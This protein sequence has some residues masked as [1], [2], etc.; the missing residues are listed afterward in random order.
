MI[1]TW[2]QIDV[3]LLADVFENFRVFS[4]ENYKLDPAHFST[5]PGLS[6]SAALVYTNIELDIPTDPDVHIFFDQ[7]LMVLVM[8]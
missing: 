8:L 5:A 6:W 4:L 7:G 3:Y 2:R 1:S